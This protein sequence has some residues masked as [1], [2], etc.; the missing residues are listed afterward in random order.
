MKVENERKAK[1]ENE[2]GG[3][4]LFFGLTT[5]FTGCW[6]Q[7][8]LCYW[9]K[10]RNIIVLVL[11]LILLFSVNVREIAI[12]TGRQAGAEKQKGDVFA[13]ITD[14]KGKI[15]RTRKLRNS[16]RDRGQ[17]GKIDRYTLRSLL[18]NCSQVTFLSF[19]LPADKNPGLFVF[20]LRLSLILENHGASLSLWERRVA[21]MSGLL[22]PVDFGN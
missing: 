19:F 11:C 5:Y 10:Y 7:G 18:G 9:R 16:N 20:P 4:F 14:S 17:P 1:V 3:H 6:G 22:T 2:S 8:R 13:T 21:V 12:Q 15:C